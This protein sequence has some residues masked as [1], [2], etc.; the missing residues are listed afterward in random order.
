MNPHRRWTQT[1]L[2]DL[3]ARVQ[4]GEE[5]LDV[6]DAIGRTIDDVVRMATRLRIK[7]LGRG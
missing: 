3:R 2:T 1:D 5:L 4:S 7:P 6:S